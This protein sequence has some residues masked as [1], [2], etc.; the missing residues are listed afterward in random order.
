MKKS[1]LTLLTLLLLGCAEPETPVPPLKNPDP[2]QHIEVLSPPASPA[3]IISSVVVVE[4]AEAKPK[5]KVEKD[6]DPALK[7]YQ[8]FYALERIEDAATG[9]W[10]KERQDNWEARRANKIKLENSPDDI[11]LLRKLVKLLRNNEEAKKQW[12]DLIRP[13]DG[14]QKAIRAKL[15]KMGEPPPE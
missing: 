15:E 8:E 11:E 13:I 9:K 5:E 10:N 2:Q 4:G 3:P 1:V 6:D 7:L 12:L 14:Q